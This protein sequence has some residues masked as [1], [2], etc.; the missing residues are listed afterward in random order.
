VFLSMLR[1]GNLRAY[2]ENL[3]EAKFTK[4]IKK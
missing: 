4:L 1:Y 2:V 3:P